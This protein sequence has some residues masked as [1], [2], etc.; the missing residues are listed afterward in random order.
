[1][2]WAVRNA[3]DI[4]QTVSSLGVHEIKQERKDYFKIIFRRH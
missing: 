3:A 2:H 1:M 4:A